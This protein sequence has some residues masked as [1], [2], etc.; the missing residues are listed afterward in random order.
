MSDVQ[1]MYDRLKRVNEPKGYF[2]S[3]NNDLVR[4]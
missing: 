1:D 4:S 2:F 3:N